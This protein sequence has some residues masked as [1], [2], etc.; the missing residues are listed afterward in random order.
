MRFT[1]D[2]FPCFVPNPTF[3]FLWYNQEIL[4]DKFNSKFNKITNVRITN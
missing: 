3:F 4:N 2:F 1:K